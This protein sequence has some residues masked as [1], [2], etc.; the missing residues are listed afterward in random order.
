MAII[1]SFSLL[2]LFY[3]F[4]TTLF[5]DVSTIIAASTV[6]S[7]TTQEI[8]LNVVLSIAASSSSVSNTKMYVQVDLVSSGVVVFDD[9]GR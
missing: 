1:S 3:I 5:A 4:M 6:I 9:T 8:S 2:M 7:L